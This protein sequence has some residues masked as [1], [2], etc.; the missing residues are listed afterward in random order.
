MKVLTLLKF[1]NSILSRKRIL[2]IVRKIEKGV[3]ENE[4]ITDYPPP[5]YPD[6]CPDFCWLC[7]TFTGTISGTDTRA[8]AKTSA[9]AD[10]CSSTGTHSCAISNTCSNSS[11]GTKGG[12]DSIL[13][14]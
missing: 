5:G 3:A 1:G 12:T 14:C 13:L 11:T 10:A 7:A 9:C 2:S 4:E 8:C 6:K